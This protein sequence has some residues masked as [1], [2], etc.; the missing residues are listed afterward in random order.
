MLGLPPLSFADVQEQLLVHSQGMVSHGSYVYLDHLMGLNSCINPYPQLVKTFSLEV[1]SPLKLLQW[2]SELK[3]H[4]D[5]AFPY[6]SC[7]ELDAASELASIMISPSILQS[8]TFTP[9]TLQL[10]QSI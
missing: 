10:Y 4:P 5:K 3:S 8:Q 2:T 9:P 1:Y 7:R 6:L